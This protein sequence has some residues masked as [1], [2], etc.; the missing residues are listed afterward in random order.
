MDT[1]HGICLL[2]IERD[3]K[4]EREVNQELVQ[5][6]G[7]NPSCGSGNEGWD[8]PRNKRVCNRYT[9]HLDGQY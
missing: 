2:Y 5:K 6:G 4:E 9:R 8:N 7:R 1:D 3:K